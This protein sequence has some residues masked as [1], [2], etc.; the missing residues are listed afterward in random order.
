[1]PRPQPTYTFL[2]ELYPLAEWTASHFLNMQH[3]FLFLL[4]LTGIAALLIYVKRP[5]PFFKS[6][7]GFPTLPMGS[8]PL[9][10]WTH[11]HS[12]VHCTAGSWFPGLMPHSK[13]G[14][15]SG[16]QEWVSFSSLNPLLHL[17]QMCSKCLLL[18]KSEEIIPVT[19]TVGP[20]LPKD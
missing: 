5:S 16:A 9:A 14:S 2:L 12:S 15:F 6:Q 11:L 10:L 4:P 18:N 13:P 20:Q 8:A 3:I 19:I 7:A 17:Q 1:M